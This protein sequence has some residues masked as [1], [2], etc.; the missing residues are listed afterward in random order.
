M[1]NRPAA[2]LLLLALAGC[3]AGGSESTETARPTTAG[4]ASPEGSSA[5]TL[6]TSF[7]EDRRAAA[8]AIE[9]L[10]TFGPT[11]EPEEA[12]APA[13]TVVFF[14]KNDKGDGPPALHNFLLGTSLEDPP[15]ATSPTLAS[16]FAGTSTIERLE[17]GTYKYWCTILAPDGTAHS[18][19]GMT[20]TLTVTP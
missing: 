11:F 17:P 19:M 13:G 4:S 5:A 16:G 2:I 20:G 10:M 7:T 15:L 8:G 3:S 6:S 9:V 14:L 1:T 12:T 18:Q